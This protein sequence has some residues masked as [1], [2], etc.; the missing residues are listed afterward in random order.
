M[1]VE[2]ELNPFSDMLIPISQDHHVLEEKKHTA[3]SQLVVDRV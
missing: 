3:L 1:C 2:H